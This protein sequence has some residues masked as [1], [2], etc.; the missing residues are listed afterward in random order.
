[1]RAGGY[2]RA[3]MDQGFTWPRGISSSLSGHRY[4]PACAMC[5]Y[6]VLAP[7]AGEAEGGSKEFEGALGG[8]PSLLLSIRSD[9]EWRVCV[10][11]FPHS[12]NTSSFLYLLLLSTHHTTYHPSTLVN[13]AGRAALST[14]NPFKQKF[15]H[16]EHIWSFC[17]VT[18]LFFLWGFSYGLLDV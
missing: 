10:L 16:R 18:T 17:L 15:I 13:M 4:G 7:D 14:A 3:G 12:T 1:M 6:G 2:V 9:L 5:D 8:V 11:Q